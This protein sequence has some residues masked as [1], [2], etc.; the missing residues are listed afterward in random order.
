MKTSCTIYHAPLACSLAALIT[1]KEGD[2][3]LEIIQVDL[4][5]KTLEDGSS[6]LDVN[7]LGQVTTLHL[8][9]GTFL[10]ETSA[11]L[12]WLQSHAA[13]DAFRR[14]PPEPEFFQM[15]RWI[16]FCATELHKQLF[17]VVFY[18]EATDGVKNK[19]RNLAPQRFAVLDDHLADRE[20]LVG[21]HFSAADAYLTWT[22]VLNARAGVDPGAFANLAAYGERMLARPLVRQVIA[23]DQARYTRMQ[24]A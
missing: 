16:G 5:A 3:P 6:F 17:R 15:L 23:E 8:P 22:F 21:D 20:F 2:V 18:D 10:T 9:D 12:V 13:S 1:A 24:P 11:A 4:N 14:T 19:F 7:P